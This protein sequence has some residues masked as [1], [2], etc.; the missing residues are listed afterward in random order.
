MRV[1]LNGWK[2]ADG[3]A[4]YCARRLLMCMI[5]YLAVVSYT[6]GAVFYYTG[7]KQILPTLLNRLCGL[8]K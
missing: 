7:C 4:D 2:G 3:Q 5:V 6:T 1:T 8:K